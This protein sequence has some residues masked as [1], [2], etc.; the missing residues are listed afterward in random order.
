M[1]NLEHGGIVIQ[2]GSKVPA[3]TVDQLA[4]FVDKDPRGMLMAPLPE[5]GAKIALT[6]WTHLA[7]CTRFD[8][9]AYLAFRDAY[10]AK[11]PEGTPLNAMQP[12]Q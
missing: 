10:R 4:A 11:G 8:E 9:K 7:M 12:G 3:A 1:H 5:L 2:Y 6:A